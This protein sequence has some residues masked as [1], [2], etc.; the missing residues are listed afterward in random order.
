MSQFPK[1]G[2]VVFATE[3]GLGILAKSLYDNGV[4]SKVL[5]V[6]HSTHPGQDWFANSKPFAPENYD[7]F[8]DGLDAVMFL[9]VPFD[10]QLLLKARERGIVTM[11]MPDE[12]TPYPL[13]YEPDII[14]CPSELENTYNQGRRCINVTVPTDVPWKL[15]R[16]AKVFIHNAGHGG[17]G[18]RNGTKELLEA[19][20]L[21]KSPIKLVIRSQ[22]PRF[23]SNDPRVTIQHGTVPHGQLWASGDV[24]V[25]PDKFAGLSMPMQEAFASGMLVMTS[26]RFPNNAWLPRDP[27]IPVSGYKTE[28]LGVEFQSAI[29]APQDIATAIDAWYNRDITIYSRLGKD[30][31]VKNSWK[32]LKRRLSQELP[33]R[34]D[35]T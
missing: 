11:L 2:S 21:I 31:A 5:I 18:G 9:E 13:R 12:C 30:W 28:R 15:R 3:Q 34:T 1:I 33:V 29:I 26:D 24:L 7:W 23:T 14:V 17:L 10:W 20:P 25:F 35:R 22:T 27:L 16:R 32:L 19:V 8:L 6:P 4:L